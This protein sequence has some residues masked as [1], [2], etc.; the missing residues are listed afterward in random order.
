MTPVGP[1]ANVVPPDA[2]PTKLDMPEKLSV[3]GPL[4]TEPAQL[5]S[6]TSAPAG[7]T[8]RLSVCAPEEPP[9]NVSPPAPFESNVV[10]S[11]VWTPEKESVVEPV[12]ESRSFAAS[13]V[14]QPGLGEHVPAASTVR[15]EVA[16]EYSS[17]LSLPPAWN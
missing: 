7:A 6:R 8:D 11:E 9:S 15:A 4:A 17:V 1:V 14:V 13:P 16:A 10:P 2:D 3:L 12:D 5:S